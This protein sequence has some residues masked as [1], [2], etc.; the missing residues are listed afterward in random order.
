MPEHSGVA[1]ATRKPYTTAASR[2]LEPQFGK[3]PFSSPAAFRPKEK[4]RGSGNWKNRTPPPECFDSN[5]FRIS[6]TET[7]IGI[8][9]I[10]SSGSGRA[11]TLSLSSVA[12]RLHTK[13]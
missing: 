10:E 1:A 6:E 9:K 8:S 5:L 3:R 12:A 4:G 7:A 2:C 11:Q 13:E